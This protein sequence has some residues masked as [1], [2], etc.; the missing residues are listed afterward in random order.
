[1]WLQ[2]C[3]CRCAYTS[4]R[5]WGGSMQVTRVSAAKSTA[6]RQ[7]MG[8]RT[9]RLRCRSCA[10]CSGRRVGACPS[11]SGVWGH[12]W[13]S[14]HVVPN[15]VFQIRNHRFLSFIACNLVAS[16]RLGGCASAGVLWLSWFPVCRAELHRRW[17]VIRAN[18]GFLAK[19]MILLCNL[20]PCRLQDGWQRFP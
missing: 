16:E 8:R 15:T 19:Q 9:W 11:L 12:S 3:K 17:G 7:G 5:G 1:M 6:E 2:A 4:M 10:C 14:F 20:R 18:R 13:V